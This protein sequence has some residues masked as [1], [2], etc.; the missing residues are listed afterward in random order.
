MS[1]IK[2]YTGGDFAL[3]LTLD[4]QGVI[5]DL[6]GATITAQVVDVVRETV[7]I[8]SVTLSD[9]AEGADWTQ[10]LVVVEIDDTAMTGVTYQGRAYLQLEVLTVGGNVRP[11]EVPIAVWR[12]N[13]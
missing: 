7:V 1:V 13:L 10:G 5:E 3:P 2:L 11:Y 8:P 4:V 9:S 6:T 12:S